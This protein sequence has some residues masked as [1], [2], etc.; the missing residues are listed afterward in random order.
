ML[1]QARRDNLTDRGES[2]PL[3]RQKAK[4]QGFSPYS[5]R[6]FLKATVLATGSAIATATISNWSQAKSETKPKIAIIGGGIAGLNAAYRLKKAGLSAT[7]YE[8][9]NRLGGR[10]FSAT[11]TV[12]EGSIVDLGGSF[13]NSEHED[14]I[15]LAK[16]FG[17]KLFERGR[18]ED[19]ISQIAYYFDGKRRSTDEIAEKL[20]PLAQQISQD[21]DRLDRDFERYAP[22]FDGISIAAYL[23]K[24]ANLIPESFIRTLIKD[25]ILTEYGVALEQSSC[26]QLLFA[27]P[28]VKGKKVEIVGGSD[29]LYILE[30]GSGSL[31]DSL[32]ASLSNQIRRGMALTQIEKKGTGFRLSFAGK[33]SVE[34]DWV[35]LA[36]PFPVLREIEIKI[37]LPEKLRRFIDEVSLGAND[38]LIA[39]FN[40]KVWQ[41]ANGFTEEL[42]TDFDFSE[43]WVESQRQPEKP[44]GI[45]TFFFGGK[46]VQFLQSGTVANRGE[47]VLTQ[48]DRA[49]SGGK[50]AANGKFS[51]TEWTKDPFTRGSYT[52]FKPG[53]LGGGR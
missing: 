14:T 43:V 41:Q 5:R 9:R 15:A 37:D 13:I 19:K 35:V 16:E 34:A 44:T 8:A 36:I 45:L 46:Q 4:K 10:I 48:F 7:V 51:R 47:A 27:L 24:Y 33:S 11:G 29:E 52:N 20:R 42:W 21:A 12:G 32:A 23:D 49:I 31:I 1:Q 22:Q 18:Q 50:A 6:R 2:L 26:L 40:N 25:V 17:L 39:G 53:V 30:K 3:T 38:K 28:T